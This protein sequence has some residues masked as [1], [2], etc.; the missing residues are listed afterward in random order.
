MNGCPMFYQLLDTYVD[1]LDLL[2]CGISDFNRRD[3]ARPDSLF[4]NRYHMKS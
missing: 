4:A 3:F 2:L 1:R